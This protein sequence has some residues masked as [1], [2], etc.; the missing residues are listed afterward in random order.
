M[1]F[2]WFVVAFLF[3]GAF[4]HAPPKVFQGMDTDKSGFLDMKELRAALESLNMPYDEL[5]I[6]RLFKRLDA[7]G[8]G[9]VSFAEFRAVLL[10]V[11]EYNMAAVVSYWERA[12]LLNLD[13]DAVAP[14]PTRVESSTPNAALINSA[15]GAV[16]SVLAKARKKEEMLFWN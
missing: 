2:V 11:P 4:A 5:A 15:A 7:N 12:A 13:D 10:H 1:A 16:A 8:D 14:S 3:V 6:N 9:L